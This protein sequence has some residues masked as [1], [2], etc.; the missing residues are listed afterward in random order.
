VDKVLDVIRSFDREEIETIR[1]SRLNGE[2][3]SADL[4]ADCEYFRVERVVLENDS[5][6]LAPTRRMRHLLCLDGKLTVAANGTALPV[7]KGE[8]VLL[9][10]ALGDV[11]LTG[12]GVLLLS[13]AY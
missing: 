10:A 7:A 9:P 4:L 3:A 12:N 13:E 6:T 5:R 2:S 8:S 11:T 1:Y